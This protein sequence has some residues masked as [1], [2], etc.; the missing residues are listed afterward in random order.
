M[1]AIINPELSGKIR[2]YWDERAKGTEP[3]SAEATTYDVYLRA[4]GDRQVQAEDF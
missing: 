4:P 3:N 1:T 2:Q